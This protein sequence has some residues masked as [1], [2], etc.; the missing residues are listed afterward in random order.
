M[1]SGSAFASRAMALMPDIAE[2]HDEGLLSIEVLSLAAL[3]FRSID[4]R[5]SAFQYV[6]PCTHLTIIFPPLPDREI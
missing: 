4:M 1:P 6:S 3:C 2:L 5:V